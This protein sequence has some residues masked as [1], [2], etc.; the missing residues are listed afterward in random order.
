MGRKWMLFFDN[1]M[2]TIQAYQHNT[3]AIIF[4]AALSGYNQLL[5]EDNR[6]NR[7][8]E[9]IGLFRRIVNLDVFRGSH[10]ILFLNKSDLFEKKVGKYSVKDHFKDYE[11]EETRDEIIKFFKTKFKEQM[12]GKRGAKCK[13][14][15]EINIH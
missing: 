15:D 9:S 5:W 13:E 7:M 8:R 6:N 4:V 2:L 3:A 10:V 11:G 14:E 12:R 1:V